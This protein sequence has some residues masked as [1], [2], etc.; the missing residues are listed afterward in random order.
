MHTLEHC[1]ATPAS[2]DCRFVTTELQVAQRH[3]MI[4]TLCVTRFLSRP[5][6]AAEI[7]MLRAVL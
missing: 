4:L 3:V 6:G 1:T 7:K 2:A 5:A